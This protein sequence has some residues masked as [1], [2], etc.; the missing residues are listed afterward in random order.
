MNYK[1]I[2][3]LFAVQRAKGL[4]YKGKNGMYHYLAMYIWAVN[5]DINYISQ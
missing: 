1:L 4:I 5:Y 2:N 3:F